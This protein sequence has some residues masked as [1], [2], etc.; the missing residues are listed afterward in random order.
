MVFAAAEAIARRLAE[1]DR[2]DLSVLPGAG[3]RL[4]SHGEV[5]PKAILMLHGYT[6]T[7]AQL[8]A[9]SE[10]FFA[11]GYN[12][13]V[14]R[15]PL[16]G[17]TRHSAHAGITAGHLRDHAGQAWAVTAGLGAEVGVLGISGGAVMATWLAACPAR[18][19]RRLLA[20]APFYRPHPR[21]ASPAAAAAMRILFGSGLIPDR[22]D[23]RGYSYTALAQYLRVAAGTRAVSA[24][25]ALSSV[26]VALSVGDT[27]VDSRT[28]LK[29]PAEIADAAGASFAS[30]LIPASA[31]LGH[32]IVTPAV[33]GTHTD[34]VH[35]RYLE[36]YEGRSASL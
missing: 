22:I 8:T 25:T 17:L 15:A 28:A 34:Q 2:T 7:P 3:T 26:A 12:V 24:S 19:V 14:P 20:L 36:L 6:H 30:H 9:L 18:A 31:G 35:A 32:D 33:L 29:V 21:Q 16:H 11:H 5:R 4:W 27:I 10:R 13:F 1:A 23:A